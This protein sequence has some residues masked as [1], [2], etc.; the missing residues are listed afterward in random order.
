MRVGGPRVRRKKKIYCVR[1]GLRARAYITLCIYGTVF[2]NCGSNGIAGKGHHKFPWLKK[3][4]VR[5]C[6]RWKLSRI[7]A[8]KLCKWKAGDFLL[9]EI[10]AAKGFSRLWA[11]PLYLYC[12]LKV[13]WFR[14]CAWIWKLWSKF[15]HNDN[16]I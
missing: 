1:E 13:A 2:L 11:R 7:A 10:T 8:E 6:A 5:V 16:I 15:L 4:R 9:T 3:F 14:Q 12:H